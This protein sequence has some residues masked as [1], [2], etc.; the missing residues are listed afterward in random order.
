MTPSVSPRLI[1]RRLV[2]SACL[3]RVTLRLAA[4]HVRIHRAAH[5]GAGAHDRHFDGEV[6]E[7]ARARA[8]QHLDL[9]ATLDLEQSDGVARADAV[10]HGGVVEIDAR[11]IG[12]PAFFARDQL[13]A[14]LDERQ[15]PEREEID[16]DEARVVAGILVPL[17]DDPVFHGGALERHDLDEGT[18][19]DHHPA[20]VLRD[21]ARQAPDFFGELAQLFPEGRVFA[22]REPGEL[23]QLVRQS[24]RPPVRQFRHQ[25]DLSERQVERFAD[26]THRRPQPVGGKGADEA[27]VLV[28]VALVD[29]ADQ[30]LADLAGKIEIDVGHRGEGVVQKAAEEEVIGDRVDVR[31]AEQV[32][33]DR[34][35]RRT[36][37]PAGK[38]IARR[39]AGAAA[40]V[41]RHLSGQL[42]QVVI[43]EEEAAEPVM[44]DQGQLFAEP[45]F[46]GAPVQRVF[47]VAIA[48]PGAA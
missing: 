48:H 32:A 14:L 13:D 40:H 41:G 27:D 17:A 43:D 31:Q 45:S 24:T 5:D 42:E 26:L 21:V 23:L 16:L 25:L 33:D 6:A 39:A 28:A 22:P 8:A 35:H 3:A 29:A 4:P 2:G 30:L 47:G 44:L 18:G 10:V 1:D 36:A 11:Q 15:H 37:S 46:G 34:R 20:D 7:I 9:R 12:G 19:G 38:E